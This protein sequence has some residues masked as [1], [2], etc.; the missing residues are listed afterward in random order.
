[1]EF[2]KHRLEL[3]QDE[4][5]KDAALVRIREAVSNGEQAST[6]FTMNHDRLPYKGRY[7]LARSSS[8][9]PVLLR[10]YHD[11]PL[12]GHAGE[13]K[14]YLQLASEW[15]WEGMRRQVTNYVRD[16]SV[17]QKVKASTQSPA[18]LL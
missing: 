11:S 13:S 12:G 7:V 10:E 18:R 8:F 1:M 5:K 2:Q 4:V 14:T 9:I 16:C 17:C 15:F 6:G 3:L